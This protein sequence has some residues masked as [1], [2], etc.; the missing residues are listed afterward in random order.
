[1]HHRIAHSE[2]G[3]PP[4][5]IMIQGLAASTN[6]RSG[7]CRPE[8]PTYYQGSM[9]VRRTTRPSQPPRTWKRSPNVCTD[10]TQVPR[11]HSYSAPLGPIGRTP[12]PRT[13]LPPPTHDTIMAP[14]SYVSHTAPPPVPHHSAV[15][16]H[17]PPT[18]VEGSRPAD[19]ASAWQN[20]KGP[21]IRTTVTTRPHTPRRGLDRPSAQ[22]QRRPEPHAPGTKRDGNK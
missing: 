15:T 6:D 10:P 4:A 20:K 2:I 21:P 17:E 13:A 7:K 3:R 12:G 16:A 9:P 8:R 11:N 1:M 22:E 5:N 14:W 19:P 18:A